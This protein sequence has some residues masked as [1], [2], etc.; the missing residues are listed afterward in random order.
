MRRLFRA[1]SPETLVRRNALWNLFGLGLPLALAFLFIPRLILGMG[2]DRFGVLTLILAFLN[3]FGFFDLGIGRALT[4]LLAGP[5]RDDKPK[6]ATLIWTVSAILIALGALLALVVF[7]VAPFLVSTLLRV[8]GPLAGETV[9][10]LRELGLALPFLLHSLAL[11]GVLEARRRFDLSNLVRIPAGVF[12][13]GAP[14]LVL[15]FSR[16]VAV[17]VAVVLAGRMLAWAMNLWMVFRIMPHV[18]TM[19]GWTP[20]EI[21]NILRFGG[22]YTVSNVVAP[23]IDSLDR[24]FI[25][26]FLSVSMVAYYTTPY[27]VIVRLGI[28]SGSVG[29]AMFPEFASRLQKSQREAAILFERGLKYLLAL[30]FPFALVATAW[31]REGLTL[32]LNPEFAALSAPVLQWLALFVFLTG[33]ALVP[34]VFL[35]GVG[36][37]DLSARMHLIELPLHAGLLFLL[38][39]LDGIR[40]AA[41]ACVLRILIDFLGNLYSSGKLMALRAGD[42]L[43]ML[44]PIGIAVVILLCFHFPMA[45]VLKAVLTLGALAGYAVV[46]WRVV[47]EERDKRTVLRILKRGDAL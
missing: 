3:Y 22:W 42:Y 18:G 29:G 32:W 31:A 44:A 28:L 12:T 5:A 4:Q 19:K 33:A 21:W 15:P 41:I 17:V 43:R 36:R 9:A 47:L 13:F 26:R 27:E 24:F 8:R 38:I 35:Q 6:E 34:L 39:R 1:P 46:G 37:P 11:R 2:A 40:G 23:V 45:P 10:A 30:L 20:G 7:L 25:G 14:V 16:N